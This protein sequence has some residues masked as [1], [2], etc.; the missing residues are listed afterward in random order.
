MIQHRILYRHVMAFVVYD[1]ETVHLMTRHHQPISSKGY[2]HPLTDTSWIVYF[3]TI[4]IITIVIH[5]ATYFLTKKTN[6]TN[7]FSLCVMFHYDDNVKMIKTI[8]KLRT[9]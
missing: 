1:A 5:W 9:G 8:P 2:T 7:V 3:I 6:F 4:F